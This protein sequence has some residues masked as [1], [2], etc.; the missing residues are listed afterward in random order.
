MCKF[1]RFTHKPNKVFAF[2][3]KKKSLKIPKG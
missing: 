2:T 3:L 1:N